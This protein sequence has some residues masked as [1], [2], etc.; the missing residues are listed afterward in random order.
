MTPGSNIFRSF[1]LYAL[2]LPVALIL[3]TLLATPTDLPTLAL[4]LSI[5]C[6]IGSPLLLKWHHPLLFLTWNMSAV[7]F[8]LPGNLQIWLVVAVG[9]LLL[10]C[11]RR[12]LVMNMRFIDA[13]SIVLPLLF[14]GAVVLMTGRFTGGL[15]MK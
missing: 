2:V 13:G 5:L 8:L 14:L 11:V 10:S 9:S 12:A 3:G 4:V 15:G 1:V 6:V 7:V